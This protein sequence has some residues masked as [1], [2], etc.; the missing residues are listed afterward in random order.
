MGLRHGWRAGVTVA[1]LMMTFGVSLAE[2]KPFRFAN[3]GDVGSMD[4]TFRNETFQ[5]TFIANIYEALLQRDRNLGLEASLAT[6]W[7][8]VEPMLWRFKLRQ[9]VKFHDGTPFTADDVVFSVNRAATAPSNM[10][11]YFASLKEV[12]KVDATTIEFET[13]VIDPLLDQKLVQIYILSKPWAEKNNATKSTDVTKPTEENY[14]TRNANGTGPFLLK[15]REPGVKTTLVP[16]PNWWGKAEHNLTDIA[17]SVIQNDAT[18]VAALLSGEI[19]FIYTVPP[20]DTERLSKADN[21]KIMQGPETR[22][23]YLGFDQARDELQE[24]NIKGKNPFKDVR[25]REAFYRAIDIEAIKTRVMRGQATPVALM[26]APGINGY[27]KA[28]DVRPKYDPDAA[29]K[30]LADAGYPNGFETGMDC[31][32]DRYVNDEAICQAVAAMLARIGI[33]VNL[34]AQTRT[35]YFAKIL[36]P[37]YNTSFYML[38]WSPAATY[39]THNVFEQLLQTRNA[40]AKKGA[41]NVGGYS[42]PQFDALTDK[43]EQEVDKAKRDAMIAEAHK[44]FQKDFANIPLHQQ[45]LIW[46]MRKSVDAVQLADN[47]FPLRFVQVK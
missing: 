7:K 12:R 35:K 47:S 21:T 4:P 20:Q 5:L 2:A 13:K 24:S 19:D 34:L 28:L 27:V 3:D 41:F 46:A 8:Q 39:D 32:N 36:G 16:N 26:V 25:V 37:G 44:I 33:K 22:V 43:L 9:G 11:G 1:A 29:R 14:A 42:N 10:T 31:P 40:A 30:L 17:F 18:R 15:L 45:A 23:V 6:E 38:G